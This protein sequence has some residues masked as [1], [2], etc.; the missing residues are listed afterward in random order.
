M[1][2]TRSTTSS[3][4]L[5]ANPPPATRQRTNGGSFMTRSDIWHD[6]GT[7]VIL[8]AETTQFRVHWSILSVN[9]MFFRDMRGLPQP[10][11]NQILKNAL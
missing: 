11:I 5:R 7:G 9:S 4:P 6:D 2:C 8:Q 10:P 3:Q 1:R